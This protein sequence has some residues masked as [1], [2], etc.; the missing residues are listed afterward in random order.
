VILP[1]ASDIRSF[2]RLIVWRPRPDFPLPPEWAEREWV[3]LGE[4]RPLL[5]AISPV[6]DLSDLWRWVVVPLPLAEVEAALAPFPDVNPL[7]DRASPAD[8][9]PAFG[10]ECQSE[11]RL[12]ARL[13]CT[14]GEPLVE[15]IE[16]GPFGSALIGLPDPG[17]NARMLEIAA[18]LRQACGCV[19]VGV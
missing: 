13:Y 12:Q 19:A 5:Q 3:P 7:S 17:L 9:E 14:D 6:R 15:R 10:A 8:P 1:G 18:A 4:M 2:R 16:L 11:D